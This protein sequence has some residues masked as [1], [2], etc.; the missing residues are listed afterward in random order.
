MT[1]FAT[2]FLFAAVAMFVGHAVEGFTHF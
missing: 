1:V 2:Y